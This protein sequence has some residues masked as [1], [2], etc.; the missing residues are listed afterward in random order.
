MR[1]YESRN[2]L[3][4]KSFDRS[5][6]RC[7]PFQPWSPSHGDQKSKQVVKLPTLHNRPSEAP[8]SGGTMPTWRRPS[9]AYVQVLA[10]A[11]GRFDTAGRKSLED[12]L[13]V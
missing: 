5:E 11:A 7:Y 9:C 6:P 12:P 8:L 2:F 3:A 1:D 10:I 13:F 4:D